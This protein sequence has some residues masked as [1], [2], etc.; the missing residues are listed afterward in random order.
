MT[1]ISRIPPTVL[2]AV[3]ILVP[4]QAAGDDWPNFRGPNHDGISAETGFT[5][6]WTTAI[7]LVWEREIGDAFS[8]FAC[9][10]DKVYTCGAEDGQQVIFCL[11]AD[12]GEVVW[13]LPFEKRYRDPQGG[14][15]T[16]ATPTVS[17][18]RVYILG[19]H[20]R[21]LCLSA[22]KGKIIWEK[23]FKH[24]PQWGYSG[25]VLIEG[26]MAVVSPG[27][28]HGS[29]IAYDKKTGKEIWKSGDDPPGYATPYPFTFNGK[30]Y[31]V[32]FMAKSAVIVEA[33]TGRQVWRTKWKTA[34]DINAADPIYHDGHL[35]LSSGYQTGSALFKLAVAGDKLTAKE[36]W[37]GKTLMNKFQTP[38]LHDGKLYGSDQKALSCV[39]FLT[40]EQMWRKNRVKHGTLILADGHLLLLTERGELQ[41]A[42]ADPSAFEPVTTAEILSGRCWTVS[43][44]HDGRLYARNLKRVVCFDLKP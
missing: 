6:A 27:D 30:R 42:P 15:G 29:L 1:T 7:P 4:L 10:G 11:N 16:R 44:L 8:S 9:V 22:D 33:G 38:I 32:G 40:G 24:K 39:D 13:K 12:N 2:L 20:G 5:T 17:E 35:F 41:I 43:V 21:L 26:N 14:D 31:I 19:G 34:Y 18:G 37:R 23:K 36:V 3:A 28:N 25:S